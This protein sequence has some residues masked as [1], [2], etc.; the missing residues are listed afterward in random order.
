MV[1][2][3]DS[4]KVQGWEGADLRYKQNFAVVFTKFGDYKDTIINAFK[5]VDA[6]VQCSMSQ[7]SM[8]INN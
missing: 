2:T 6:C 8:P 1:V 7:F 3:C 4:G 5:D